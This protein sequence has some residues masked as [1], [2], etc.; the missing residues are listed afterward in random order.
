M[1]KLGILV[2]GLLAIANLAN[3]R[4]VTVRTGEHDGYT[5]LVVQVPSGTDWTLAQTRNGAR[6]SV[7]LEDV[8]FDTG[9]VFQRLTQNRLAAISQKSPGEALEMQFGCDCVASSFLYKDT[10]IVVDITAAKIQPAISSDIPPPLLPKA[11]PA[12]N[13][14]DSAQPLKA[15]SLPVVNLNARLLESQ[16]STRL[17]QGADRDLVD[18][19]LA[20]VG[21]RAS[22]AKDV[23]Q[24]PFDLNANINVTSVVDELNDQFGAR[25]M[26]IERYPACFTSAD[27]GFDKWSE[28]DPF[29]LQLA[30]LRTTLFQEFDHLDADSALKLAKLYAF[31]GFG[32]ES[33][34]MLELLGKVSSPE[35]TRIAAIA[36]YLDRGGVSDPN[37]FAGLQN[38]ESDAALWSVLTEGVLAEDAAL[39]AIEQSFA[40]LPRHLRRHLGPE[41]SEIF[42]KGKELEAARRVMRGVGRVQ[43]N[44]SASASN[45][46]AK[47]AASD[48][49]G[50]LAETL[51]TDAISA[52]GSTLEAPVAL[53]RLV[54][55]R[56]TDRGS[57]SAKE[58][59]LAASF[60]AE[61]RE[62][63]LQPVLQRTHAVA[64]GLSQEFDQSL[65]ILEEIP[66]GP[67]HDAGL[68][69]IKQVLTERADDTTFLRRVLTMSAEHRNALTTSTAIAVAD[70]LVS[71]GFARPAHVL[72]SRSQDKA[73]AA[74]RARL[75]AHSALLSRRPHQALLELADDSSKKATQIKL[76]ALQSVNDYATAG[77]LSLA[78]GN[79][80]EA[81]RFFWLADLPDEVDTVQG[82]RFGRISQTTQNLSRQPSRVPGK[83]LADARTLL[84]DS[85]DT[86]QQIAELLAAVVR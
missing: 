17:L 15:L 6:L 71:L 75:R 50:P 55:K 51:L 38:C 29:P 46:N 30:E 69:Q 32:A 36:Q 67:E 83:P 43:T 21:P 56:W 3:A 26:P 12:P 14:L 52:P 72:A 48:G 1:K 4:P 68:N 42:V 7:A 18:L 37:P 53:V 34:R 11:V 35:M 25:L 41:L 8:T 73:R 57:V 19:E 81:N 65:D 31:H 49:D 5:R 84:Q 62:S 64:L 78:L 54:D 70:R 16:L 27:L 79:Y 63:S 59:A 2:A 60:A 23:L 44:P 58:V 39:N 74:D 80:D 28:A 10:M 47:I 61:L 76:Q 13:P 20:P 82:P 86:R 9:S 77:S 24:Q 40:R 85:A 45:A 33:L 66:K 22:I